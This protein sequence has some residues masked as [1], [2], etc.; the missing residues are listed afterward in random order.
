MIEDLFQMGRYLLI[1]AS[2]PGN[3]PANLVGLWIGDKGSWKDYHFNID[4]QENYWPAEVANLSELAMPFIDYI[5]RARLGDGHRCAA[6]LGCRG[7]VIKVE[8][9]AWMDQEFLR[10][11]LVGNLRAECRVGLRTRDGTLLLHGR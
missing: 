5:D 2:R 3:L 6:N 10:I 8:A 1:S 7:F 9:T 11:E 4:V